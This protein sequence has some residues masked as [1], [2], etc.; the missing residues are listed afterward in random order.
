MAACSPNTARRGHGLPEET[1]AEQCF[2][3]SGRTAKR[4]GGFGSREPG[5]VRPPRRSVGAWLRDAHG[6]RTEAH[7]APAVDARRRTFENGFDPR[8]Q[9]RA[10]GRRA[11]D[12][13]L[14]PAERFAFASRPPLRRTPPHRRQ[15]VVRRGS[16]YVENSSVLMGCQQAPPRQDGD[17]GRRN[18]EVGGGGV[19]RHASFAGGNRGRER[20]ATRKVALAV[21]GP[22]RRDF[23]DRTRD[24]RPA[25]HP[26]HAGAGRTLRGREPA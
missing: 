8:G 7:A 13:G 15:Q 23:A 19:N 18:A 11:P 12:R 24:A 14:A 5:S 22:H 10:V 16:G 21:P 26:A 6:E 3:P 17:R 20:P 9:C 2:H 25:A 1:R 4:R